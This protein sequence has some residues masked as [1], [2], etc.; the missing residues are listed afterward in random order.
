ME[1]ECLYGLRVCRGG[2]SDCLFRGFGQVKFR[3]LSSSL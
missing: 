1:E 3:F 2:W